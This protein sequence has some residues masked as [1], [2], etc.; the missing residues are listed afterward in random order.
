MVFLIHKLKITLIIF[1]VLAVIALYFIW[2]N[3]DLTVSRY[4]YQNK[5]F[6][7]SLDG[8]KI[9]QISD[10]HNKLF[11]KNQSRLL[12]LIRRENPD[13]IVITGDIIDDSRTDVAAAL[14]L[15][16]GLT[17]IAPVY[18]VTGNHEL[19][20]ALPAHNALM[21]GLSRSGVEILDNEV[22]VVAY[23]NDS[24]YLIG[25]DDDSRQ[26]GTL[27]GLVSGLDENKP[28]ILLVHRPETFESYAETGVD[29]VFAGHAH[30]GQ[31]R[32]PIVGGLYAPGQGFFPKYSCGIYTYGSSTMIVSRGLGNSMPGRINNRPDLVVV[33][34]DTIGT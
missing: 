31:I 27:A 5:N 2:Q 18:Y 19:S 10:L 1:A 15:T 33:T 26:D 24:F 6:G 29:L 34:L 32:L 17:D 13:L 25:L 7:S 28:E 16:D 21:Q 9:C 14:V 30:G 4:A 12:N 8:Y 3:N 11:G 22:R 20:A 23:G